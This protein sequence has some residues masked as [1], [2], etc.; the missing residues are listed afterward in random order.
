MRENFEKHNYSTSKTARFAL[1]T[2]SF[3]DFANVS[4]KISLIL[5]RGAKREG[6]A[7]LEGGANMQRYA[8]AL[9]T[10]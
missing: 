6:G 3:R 4:F 8:T 10:G 2:H 1:E 5:G 7:F 9:I